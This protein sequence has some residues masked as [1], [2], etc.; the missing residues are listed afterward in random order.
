MI[1]VFFAAFAS[2]SL[3]AVLI[4]PT[5]AISVSLPSDSSATVSRI[6]LALQHSEEMLLQ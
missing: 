4:P 1:S 2:T 5:C 6:F 3:S